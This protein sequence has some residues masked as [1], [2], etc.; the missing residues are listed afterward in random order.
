MPALLALGGADP[1]RLLVPL[2][3]LGFRCNVLRRQ[4]LSIPR[5][6][7]SPLLSGGVLAPP[8]FDKQIIWLARLAP[9]QLSAFA[10]LRG[11]PVC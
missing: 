6:R 7:G 3:G 4:A 8:A 10:P 5:A 9:V 2:R 1:H 11:H